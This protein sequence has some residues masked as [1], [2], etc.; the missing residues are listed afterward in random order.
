MISPPEHVIEL[1]FGRWRSQILYAG[2]ALRI[3]AKIT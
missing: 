3:L 2:A 1:I